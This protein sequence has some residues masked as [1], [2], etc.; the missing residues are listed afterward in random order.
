MEGTAAPDRARREWNE[1]CPTTASV[2]MTD[3]ELAEIVPFSASRSAIR[4]TQSPV[5]ESSAATA[6]VGQPIRVMAR[7][8]LG[9]YR[10]APMEGARSVV[11]VASRSFARGDDR[12]GIARAATAVRQG[13]RR[14]QQP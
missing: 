8:S 2:P 5:E 10:M 6:R 3:A 4:R 9:T 7:R 12:V 1:T 11:E 13:P 14:N